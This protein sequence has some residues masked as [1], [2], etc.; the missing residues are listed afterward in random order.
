MATEVES[1]IK[2]TH[3]ACLVSHNKNPHLLYKEI[4]LNLTS[5]IG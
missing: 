4:K 5:K 3:T 1:Y 2:K